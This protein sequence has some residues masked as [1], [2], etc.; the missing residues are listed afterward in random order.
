MVYLLCSIYNDFIIDSWNM[1]GILGIWSNEFKHDELETELRNMSMQQLHRG[2]DNNGVWEDKDNYFYLSH[3]R[4]SILD[5][6]HLGNQPM[7]SR[8]GRYVISFNGEIYNFKDLRIQLEKI[9]L[10]V[11]WKSNSDTEILLALIEE[12]GLKEALEK[13]VGM[14]AFA[15]WDREQKVLKI[16]R[17]RIGEKP[18]YYGYINKNSKKI[19]TKR[20][21]KLYKKKRKQNLIF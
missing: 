1:C 7:I 6:S 11:K 20:Y 3:Q 16:V 13:C 5:L 15:L 21:L 17:D 2:P 18:V 14:F 4:L 19:K 9:N 8:S 10:S 12:F